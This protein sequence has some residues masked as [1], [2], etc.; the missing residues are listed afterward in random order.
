ME[1]K[2]PLGFEMLTNPLTF[3]FTDQFAFLLS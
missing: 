2:L 3:I 1:E